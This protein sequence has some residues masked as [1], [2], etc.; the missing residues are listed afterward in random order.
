MRMSKS[1]WFSQ[2]GK[3]LPVQNEVCQSDARRRNLR[4][5]N[6]KW[7][8]SRIFENLRPSP[9]FSQTLKP[10]SVQTEVFGPL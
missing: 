10:L 5:E 3:P 4:K 8:L 9:W 1:P 6:L 7:L 2:T